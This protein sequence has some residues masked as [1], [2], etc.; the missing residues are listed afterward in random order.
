MKAKITTA[1]RDLAHATAQGKDAYPV[2]TGVR[3]TRREATATNGYLVVIKQLPPPEME[4]D[5]PA[6]NDGIGEVN[7]PADA[8]LACKGEE[9]RMETSEVRNPKRVGQLDAGHLPTKLIV[10]MNGPDFDVEA[11]SIV[12]TFPN[13]EAMFAP[14][15]L[16]GQIAFNTNVIKKLLKALP[17]DSFF[18]LRISDP[19][20]AV[21]FEC[22]DPDGDIPIRGLIAPMQMSVENLKWKCQDS[23]GLTT[24]DVVMSKMVD[25]LK[26][27]ATEPPQPGE[28]TVSRRGICNHDR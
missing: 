7:V 10:R 18:A 26:E 19:E 17:D 3:F 27:S 6:K 13:V 4:M 24:V 20:K 9:I 1:V 28:N 16:R 2:M 21:E 25:S 12:G 11:D 8:L 23:T 15:P 5:G 14:S 22:I